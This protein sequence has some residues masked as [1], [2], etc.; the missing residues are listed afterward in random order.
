[1]EEKTDA[2]PNADT[3]KLMQLHFRNLF[4]LIHN[5]K[6]EQEQY[7]ALAQVILT[8]F[9]E[10][11]NTL[12]THYF[13]KDGETIQWIKTEEVFPLLEDASQP[14]PLHA[15]TTNEGFFDGCHTQ[16]QQS[17]PSTQADTLFQN[18]LHPLCCA[19]ADLCVTMNLNEARQRNDGTPA[20]QEQEAN[21][22]TQY[23][24]HIYAY[25]NYFSELI[26]KQGDTAKLHEL[27]LKEVKEEKGYPDQ[28]NAIIRWL[29]ATQP[30]NMTDK[31]AQAQSLSLYPK[32]LCVEA[33]PAQKPVETSD[34]C[35][36][37]CCIA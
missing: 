36:G 16:S 12:T 34:R 15:L 25:A 7:N 30:Q 19:L 2:D 23:L 9:H 26:K 37:S 17:L 10:L 5:T 21:L 6:K 20:F 33:N 35:C 31:A 4:S 29:E 3:R 13:K 24:G 28:E 27:V 18:L 1:M 11:H 8:S 32:P 22:I 14:T